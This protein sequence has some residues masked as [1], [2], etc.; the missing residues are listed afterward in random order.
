MLPCVP[1]LLLL[2]ELPQVPRLSPQIPHH[3]V[4]PEV[5]GQRSTPP[6]PSPSRTGASLGNTPGSS[7]SQRNTP[8]GGLSGTTSMLGLQASSSSAI[9]VAPPSPP[10]RRP[11]SAAPVSNASMQAGMW[12]SPPPDFPSQPGSNRRQGSAASLPSS[13]YEYSAREVQ[14]SSVY[15]SERSSAHSHLKGTL[16][17]S[18]VRLVYVTTPTVVI[19][20]PLWTISPTSSLCP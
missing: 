3:Q 15:G 1:E 2:V 5:D 19:S 12:P 8:G 20:C 4:G 13:S 11:R 7:A 9:D 6:R 18:M 17:G 14:G 16:L 10:A